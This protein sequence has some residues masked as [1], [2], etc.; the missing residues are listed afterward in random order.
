M[1]GLDEI[2]VAIGGLKV[3][4]EEAMRQNARLERMLAQ[5]LESVDKTMREMLQELRDRYHE[6]HNRMQADFNT[7]GTDMLKLQNRLTSIEQWKDRHEAILR[8]NI[9][10]IAGISSFISA[11]IVSAVELFIYL[12]GGR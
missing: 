8:A 6:K 3:A 12:H 10:W 7:M 4:I 5:G 11:L 1:P 9:K 2:S